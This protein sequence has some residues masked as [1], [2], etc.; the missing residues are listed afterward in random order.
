MVSH[1]NCKQKQNKAIGFN[2]I[3]RVVQMYCIQSNGTIR[4]RRN[5]MYGIECALFGAMFGGIHDSTVGP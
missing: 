4:F 1:S 2:K 3:V 5:G